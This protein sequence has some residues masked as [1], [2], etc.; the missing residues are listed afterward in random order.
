[1]KF[2]TAAAVVTATVMT[3]GT[4]M[5]ACDTGEIVIKFSHVTN[6]DRHPKGI[7]ASLL[8]QRVNDEMDGKA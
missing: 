6:T 4:A 5:A 8:Q 1:M 3:A 2:M 7:A